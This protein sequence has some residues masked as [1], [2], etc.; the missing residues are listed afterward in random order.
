MAKV[1]TA[2]IGSGN[3]G[4]D[5]MYKILRSEWLEL[6]YMV[7]VDP[8]SEGLAQ[9]RE[10]GITTTDQGIEKFLE[11]PKGVEI[12][13]DATSA[14]AHKYNAPLLQQARA[15]MSHQIPTG[16]IAPVLKSALRLFV[17]HHEQRKYAATERPIAAKV[18]SSSAPRR[19]MAQQARS[20][21]SWSC[22][23]PA[24]RSATT[25][26]GGSSPRSASSS[27]WSCRR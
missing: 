19:P 6:V 5:L 24:P 16:E 18:S 21:A 23:W 4:A 14:K 26:A 1:K 17:T 25:T 27:R 11:D 12:A 2:I 3:I 13:Y 9:A 10:H 20:T 8:A 22:A 7:G 15:L